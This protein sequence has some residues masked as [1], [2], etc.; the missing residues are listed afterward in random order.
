MIKNFRF[1]GSQLYKQKNNNVKT[2]L[3]FLTLVFIFAVQNFIF[4]QG[5][6]SI[7]DHKK[8]RFFTVDGYEIKYRSLKE[9][10][11]MVI[12]EVTKGDFKEMA[13]DQIL[14]VEKQKGS[15]ALMWTLA[16]SASASVGFLIGSSVG[17]NR[18]NDK[19]KRNFLMVSA[20]VGGLY[21]FIRGSKK[22]KFR[23]VY[24]YA[25][26]N[27]TLGRIQFK[28]NYVDNISSIGFVYR[29]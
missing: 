27:S 17:K 18:I 21:G 2:N 3:T 22:K 6:S 8:G 10:D 7:P 1:L 13:K 5:S 12:Y 23:K 4:S 15:E 29:F 20:L 24:E 16:C 25:E 26:P 9:S 19:V 11:N 14:L 28:A